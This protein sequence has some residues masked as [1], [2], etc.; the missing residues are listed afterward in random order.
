M[1]TNIIVGFVSTTNPNGDKIRLIF[2]HKLK[3]NDNKYLDNGG[4]KVSIYLPFSPRF[5][6]EWLKKYLD[7]KK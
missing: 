4:D 3:L 6:E 2:D 5:D 7:L 1:S